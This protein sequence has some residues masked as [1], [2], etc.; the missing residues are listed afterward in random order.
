MHPL[1]CEEFEAFCHLRR[2]ASARAQRVS[3]ARLADPFRRW[4]WLVFLLLY[5]CSCRSPHISSYVSK[6]DTTYIHTINHDSIHTIDSVYIYH[7]DTTHI[8]YK[9]R[10]NY[11]YK[12]SHDTL[13]KVF[14]DTIYLTNIHKSA[15]SSGRSSF[16]FTYFCIF[17]VILFILVFIYLKRK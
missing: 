15:S 12:I 7:N 16:E 13:Y 2:L 6:N 17:V 10:N 9:S 3:K 5:I 4:L 14:R 11:R 1:K 8:I